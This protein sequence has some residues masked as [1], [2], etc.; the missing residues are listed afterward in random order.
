M[1]CASLSKSTANLCQDQ[2]L[3]EGGVK[4]ETLERRLEAG[5]K[6]ADQII[7]L[8]NDV[9]KAKKQEKV[10]EDAI[11]Q[12]QKDLDVLEAE[13]AQLGKR[14]TGDPRQSQGSFPEPMHLGVTGIEASHLA[15][16]VSCLRDP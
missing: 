8:E 4:I 1:S 13:N 10:Y 15:E 9:A 5:R 14:H 6:Q 3:Q 7:E 16:Q 2:S 11:E 12:L